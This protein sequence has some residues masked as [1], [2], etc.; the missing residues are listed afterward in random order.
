MKDLNIGDSLWYVPADSRHSNPQGTYKKVTKVGR[1]YFYV[2][3]MKCEFW[4]NDTYAIAHVCEY[5]YGS[6]YIDKQ[7]HLESIMWL[8]FIH[9]IPSHFSREQKNLIL[10]I[11]KGCY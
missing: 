4:E 3:G 11:V 5:P 1:K 6:L 2:D 8:D 9:N 7:S 10:K